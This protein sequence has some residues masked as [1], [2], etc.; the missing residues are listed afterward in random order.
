MKNTLNILKC[1]YGCE[2]DQLAISQLNLKELDA[3]FNTKIINVNH[4]KDTLDILYCMDSSGIDQFG[5]SELKLKILYACG[6]NKIINA[7]SL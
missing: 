5:I 6:N 7:R 2:I 3:C 4:M 1:T